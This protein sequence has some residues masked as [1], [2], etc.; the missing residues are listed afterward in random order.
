MGFYAQMLS[1]AGAK[2]PEVYLIAVEKKEPYRVVVV[3][4]VG[5][6]VNDANHNHMGGETWR[7]DND[8]MIEELKHCRAKGVWP[9]RYEKVIHI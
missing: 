8:A 4:I 5:M 3:N 2:L 1:I 7:D 6:T 9:T